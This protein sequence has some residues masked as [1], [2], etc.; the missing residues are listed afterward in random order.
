L[1]L[2]VPMRGRQ[3]AF[4]GR[5]VLQWSSA[6]PTVSCTGKTSSSLFARPGKSEC[7]RP[8]GSSAWADATAERAPVHGRVARQHSSTVVVAHERA[9]V[10]G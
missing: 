10:G 1:L 5:I 9:G 2:L 3:G 7:V 8:V 4:V 6:L